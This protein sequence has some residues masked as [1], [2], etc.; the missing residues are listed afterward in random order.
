M[1]TVNNARKRL[2]IATATTATAATKRA[3]TTKNNEIA[4][5]SKIIPFYRPFF[6]EKPWPY[7]Y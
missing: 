6:R 7:F 1:A 5:L 3:A 4:V 2:R